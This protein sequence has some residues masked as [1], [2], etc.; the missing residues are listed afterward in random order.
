MKIV[1]CFMALGVAV[2]APESKS[3]R[4]SRGDRLDEATVTFDEGSADIGQPLGASLD[5]AAAV[6]KK[7]SSKKNVLL[8]GHTDKKGSPET[9]R[10]LSI[11]R[12]NSVRREL[13]TR[14]VDPVMLSVLGV[15]DTELLDK[16]DTDEAHATN[17]RVEAWLTP[18][19]PVG[20]VTWIRKKVEAREPAGDQWASA[21]LDMPLLRRFQ[22]RT[23]DDSASEVTFLRESKLYM[24]ENAL[25]IIYDTTGATKRSR[26]RIADVTVEEGDIFARLAT[27]NGPALKIDTPSA[28]IDLR[29]QEARLNFSKKTQMASLSVFDGNANVS[30]SGRTVRVR[31][32]QGTRIK[33]GKPPEAPRPLPKPPRWDMQGPALIQGNSTA[34][35]YW[36]NAVRTSSVVVE[37]ASADDEKF[38]RPVK[39]KEVRG[40]RVKLRGLPVSAYYVRLTAVDQTGLYSPPSALMKLL[41]MPAPIALGIELEATGEEISMPGPGVFRQDGIEGFE[42]VLGTEAEPAPIT[43][44]ELR[45]PG[46]YTIPY[47]VKSLDGTTF[48]GGAI[49]VLVN[50]VN[51]V[52]SPLLPVVDK[53][54]SRTQVQFRVLGPDDHP[55]GGMKFR[56]HKVEKPLPGLAPMLTNDRG[57][58]R[59]LLQLCEQCELPDNAPEIVDNGDGVYT[60]SYE[61]I[62]GERFRTDVVRFIETQSM[63]VQEVDVPIGAFAYEEPT[64]PR[65]GL[66]GAVRFGVQVADQLSP[67]FRADIEFGGRLHMFGPLSLDLTAEAS[68]FRTPVR[69]LDKQPSAANVV[70]AQGRLGLVFDIDG[71]GFYA[72]GSAGAS[73][74]LSPVAGS[75]AGEVKPIIFVW[76]GFGGAFYRTGP[77]EVVVE[78]G[79][80]TNAL[81]GTDIKAN[82]GPTFSVGYRFTPWIFSTADIDV[83]EAEEV[84]VGTDVGG[85]R[86]D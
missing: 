31:K 68:Y 19:K 85:D 18:Q 11:S 17:R 64:L 26:R 28:K 80:G 60:F 86:W 24:G 47:R 79:F 70:P 53:D 55:V 43:G 67:G 75:G 38:E 4:L 23:L 21:N 58:Q 15:G 32:N 74:Q 57:E 44:I 82:L 50:K 63:M 81:T 73:F 34:T 45:K 37:F 61:R 65:S 40:E 71:W 27:P 16:A 77:G 76:Q 22:V 13:I 52:M 14:G 72:G 51:F 56:L 29:S 1:A 2:G 42:L 54:I 41:V 30:A 33:T 35:L 10:R 78:G 25:V 66:I 36:K 9:N 39:R 8:V 7:L 59:G 49:K 46:R 48:T 12:A 83:R 62:A 5:K 84:D 20:H 3:S 6:L 69:I